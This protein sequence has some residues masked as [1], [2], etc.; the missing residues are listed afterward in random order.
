MQ[1]FTRVLLYTD[2]DGRAKFREE[3]VPLASGNPQA[4]QAALEVVFIRYDTQIEVA[5][6]D[7][8]LANWHP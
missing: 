5:D 3:P 2:R 8:I 4:H 1:T 7:T 6:T